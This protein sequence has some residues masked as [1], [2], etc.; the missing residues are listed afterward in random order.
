MNHNVDGFCK[1]H[2]VSLFPDSAISAIGRLSLIPSGQAVAVLTVSALGRLNSIFLTAVQSH[3]SFSRDQSCSS[4][5]LVTIS[6][7]CRLGRC[8]QQATRRLVPASIPAIRRSVLCLL[9]ALSLCYW[10]ANLRAVRAGHH[11]QLVHSVGRT[12][13]PRSSFTRF[14]SLWPEVLRGSCISSRGASGGAYVYLLATGCST[15][16]GGRSGGG[17]CDA[18]RSWFPSAC[19][20]NVNHKEFFGTSK[21]F[22]SPL[23]ACRSFAGIRLMSPRNLP[24]ASSTSLPSMYDPPCGMSSVC[25]INAVGILYVRGVL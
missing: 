6:A 25:K 12:S 2:N 14:I 3:R 23:T 19:P 24:L 1:P 15:W 5:R 11:C 7:H 18:P 22:V 17:S 20:A 21:Y 10:Q 8:T 4:L 16:R 9:Q 13:C